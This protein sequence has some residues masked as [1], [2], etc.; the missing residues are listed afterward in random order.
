MDNNFE[1]WVKETME[2]HP[3]VPFNEKAW[4]QLQTRLTAKPK[5]PIAWKA[6][7]PFLFLSLFLFA[8]GLNYFVKYNV[9]SEKIS[10]LENQLHHN[11]IVVDTLYEKHVVVVY[12]TTFTSIE[13]TI[14]LLNLENSSRK[15]QQK[16]RSVNN[17]TAEGT[18][19]FSFSA[20]SSE[21]AYQMNNFLQF[22]KASFKEPQTTFDYLNANKNNT[23]QTGTDPF[24][25]VNNPDEANAELLQS[26]LLAVPTLNST[27]FPNS[28]TDAANGS[29]AEIDKSKRRKGFG[30]YLSYA[31]P[32]QISLGAIVGRSRQ[33][34]F[35]FRDY[36]YVPSKDNNLGLR[37][38]VAYGKH[39][40][41]VLGLE[42]F[43]NNYEVYTDDTKQGEAELK[44]LFPDIPSTSDDD[45]LHEIIA[46]F[47]YLQIPIAFQYRFLPTK[48]LQPY[49]G[50]GIM[51]RRAL[52]S[53]VTFEY[54]SPQ[55]VYLNSKSKLLP[56]SFQLNTAFGY[57]GFQYH[58]TKNWRL[59]FEGRL[60]NDFGTAKKYY[61]E[62]TRMF[63]LN[64]GLQYAF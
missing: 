57:L 59:L 52:K 19:A 23:Y 1:D 49:I 28:M 42:Y 22:H 3:E 9:A 33:I 53:N 60:E 34:D 17:P 16:S 6:W 51:S 54:Q 24:S 44:M 13:K 25:I 55:G 21:I 20:T 56:S 37:G 7:L 35:D 5:T 8:G 41:I 47:S 11:F 39:F 58:L 46:D 48:R 2:D 26:Q 27:L 4:G 36:H 62:Q 32:S 30:Y 64:T 14:Q 10:L 18:N 31:Q 40:S 50:I 63:K 15:L 29:L 45:I 61:Y 12:D 38:E 43:T